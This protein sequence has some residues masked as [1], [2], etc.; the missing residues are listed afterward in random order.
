MSE[1]VGIDFKAPIIDHPKVRTMTATLDERLPFPDESFDVVT[2]LAVLEHLSRPREI[3][4]EISRVLRPGGQVVLT[5][6]S[7]IAKPVLEFLAF[8]LGVIS[9]DE[10]RD[11]KRYYDR[12]SLAELFQSTGLR[13]ERHA[14]FQF[15]MNNFLR[16]TKVSGDGARAVEASPRR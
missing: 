3:V 11:H 1:A 8:R 10:I 16:A 9:K 14:Y 7:P 6:P 5:V 4:Q 13:I 15:G 2:M 12:A